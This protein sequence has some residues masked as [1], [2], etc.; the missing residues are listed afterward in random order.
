MS[1]HARRFV[2]V[3]AMAAQICAAE[4]KDAIFI[5]SSLDLFS[6]SLNQIFGPEESRVQS[7]QA[8]VQA[9]P[10]VAKSPAANVEDQSSESVDPITLKEAF[11]GIASN[12]TSVQ[13][14]AFFD[15]L[16]EKR[17]SW[18]GPVRDVEKGWTA[19]TVLVSAG[20]SKTLRCD[21]SFKLP[22]AD[23]M[24]SGISIGDTVRCT[25]TPSQYL[26]I[27]GL[28]IQVDAETVE[29]VKR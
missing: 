25:G 14:E 3:V 7:A 19:Y 8:A 26:T 20:T 23:E 27:F 9:A 4:A 15:S 22:N 12:R 28:S 10:E 17:V 6:D 5:E 21:V 1:K 16:K 24:A 13:K 18:Q 11:A 29:I 2:F